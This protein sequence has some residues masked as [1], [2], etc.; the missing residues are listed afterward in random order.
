LINGKAGSGKSTLMRFIVQSRETRLHLRHWA[1]DFDLLVSSFYFWSGGSE[2]QRSRK[3][4]LQSFLFDILKERPELTRSVFDIEWKEF[5]TIYNTFNV[6]EPRKWEIS[7][8]RM[9]QC[10]TKLIGLTT[11]RISALLL[12]RRLR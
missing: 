4:L 3:G 1:M 6:L 5:E 2:L 8:K 7:T 10:F 12:H 11:K 9:E